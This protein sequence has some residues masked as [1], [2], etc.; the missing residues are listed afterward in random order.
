ML[1][2][3]SGSVTDVVGRIVSVYPGT[4]IVVSIVACVT[5]GFNAPGVQCRSGITNSPRPLA[6]QE[7]AG[8]CGCTRPADAVETSSPL[9]AWVGVGCGRFG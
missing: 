2:S 8:G 6:W 3:F 9:D 1:A 4:Q 7:P 5:A